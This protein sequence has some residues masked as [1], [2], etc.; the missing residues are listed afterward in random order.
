LFKRVPVSLPAAR[1]RQFDVSTLPLRTS[2][3][4]FHVCCDGSDDSDDGFWIELPNLRGELRFAP[5]ASESALFH[6]QTVDRISAEID[7]VAI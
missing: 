4:A 7:K 6:G 5:R 3:C 2:L 1:V